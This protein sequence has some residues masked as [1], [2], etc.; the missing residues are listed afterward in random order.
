MYKR[1]AGNTVSNTTRKNQEKINA[2]V[3]RNTSYQNNTCCMSPQRGI[4]FPLLNKN[5][6]ILI[7]MKK[8]GNKRKKKKKTNTT[9]F[10][11]N[12]TTETFVFLNCLD[13][14]VDFCGNSTNVLEFLMIPPLMK[15]IFFSFP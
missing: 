2:T 8:I 6:V 13:I 1:N 11:K 7:E 5:S 15:N 10:L 3:E 4:G 9:K 12:E 14:I